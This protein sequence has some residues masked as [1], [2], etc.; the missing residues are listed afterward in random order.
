MIIIFVLAIE[1]VY[2]VIVTALL[3]KFVIFTE[4]FSYYFTSVARKTKKRCFLRK[5]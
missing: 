1:F 3:K 5:K 2:I 4:F